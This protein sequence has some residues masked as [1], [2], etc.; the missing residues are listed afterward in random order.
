MADQAPASGDEKTTV[1]ASTPRTDIDA[2][3]ATLRWFPAMRWSRLA[4]PLGVLTGAVVMALVAFLVV[5]VLN[6]PDPM[7]PGELVIL[8]SHDQTEGRIREELINQWNV[9]Y[10]EHKARIEELPDSTDDQHSEMVA[11]AQTDSSPVDI[12]N[13][14]VTWIA[15]FAHAG[16]LTPLEESATDTDGFLDKPLQTCRYDGKLWGLPFNTDAGLLYYRTPTIRSAPST[17]EALVK[18][19]EQVF[20]GQQDSQLRAGYT[21]QLRDYEGLVVNALEAI[22][23][24]GGD[25]VDANGEV[26]IDSEQ[27]QEGLHRLAAGL[28]A[29]NPPVI[30]PDALDHDETLSWK[31]LAEGKVLFMRNWP[32]AYRNLQ[33]Q[34]EEDQELHQWSFGVAELPGPSVLGGQNLAI[35]SKSTKPRAAKKLIEFLTGPRS[36]QILFEHGGLAASRKIV[37][38]DPQVREQHPY[39]DTLLNAINDA[40]LRPITPHYMR[41]AETFRAIVR[42][43]LFQDGQVSSDAKDRLTAAL[44]GG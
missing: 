2:K 43:A 39:T 44:R 4:F 23:A 21:T 14:D 41:F 11:R 5:P 7:E 31:A 35:S 24:A 40:R 25:V 10:P 34:V 26:V 42:Q 22:W 12:Y 20:S 36:Q 8:S 9:L 16:Y 1:P 29:A 27:A 3:S 6:S 13:L 28:A 37:Y 17:W 19:T 38:Q 18:Q 32:V 15:P 30:L 33:R